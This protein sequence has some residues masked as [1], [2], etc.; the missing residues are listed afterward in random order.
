[1]ATVIL[2]LPPDRMTFGPLPFDQWEGEPA[3]VGDKAGAPG[4]S[5]RGE[6]PT[7]EPFFF[8]T[9]YIVLTTNKNS[10]PSKHRRNTTLLQTKT[11]NTVN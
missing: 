11:Y 9:L 8:C 3:E 6:L 5:P 2:Y 1:M 10:R 7:F 4:A